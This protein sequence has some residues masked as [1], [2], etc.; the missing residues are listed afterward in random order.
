VDGLKVQFSLAAPTTEP[1]RTLQVETDAGSL[2][3]VVAGTND[4]QNIPTPPGKT[5]RLRLS[6]GVTDGK[7]P[8]GVSIAEITLPGLQPVSRLLVP[9]EDRQPSALVFRNQQIGRSA[10]LHAGTRPLCRQGFAKD[11]EE[12]TGLMRSVELPQAASYQLQGTALPRDGAALEGML[13]VPGAITASASSR[14]VT[15]PE[16]RPG[17]A[18]DRDQGT[19]WVASSSDLHPALTLKLPEARKL[20]GLQFLA[21]P[22]LAASQPAEVALSFDGGTPVR[23]TVDAEGYVRFGARKARTIELT[24]T[25]TKPLV[26]FDSATGYAQTAPVGVAEVRVLGADDLRKALDPDSETGAYCGYGPGVRV[27]GVPADTQLKATVGDLLQRRPVTYTTC[28][29][30]PLQAGRHTLDVLATGAFV[31]VEATFTKAGYGNVSQT[32]VQGIDVWRPNPAELSVEVPA[33]DERSVLT[34]AQNYNEGWEAYDGSGRKL[35]PIRVDGWQ[36]GWILPV[37]PEQ[38]V[39]ARFMPDRMYR[40][41]LLVGLLGLL[42]VIAAAVFFRRRSRHSRH[43][44]R[45]GRSVGPWVALGLGLAA[46]TFM[47]GWIGFAAVAIAAACTWFLSTRVLLAVLAGAVT[48]GTLIAVVQP[49]PDGGA[50]LTSGVVQASIL[51]GC[52]LALLSRPAGETS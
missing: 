4:P 29:H 33:A 2:A 42:V 10:C 38:V 34:V 21:D 1:V 25:G 51:F 5:Q 28:E 3:S 50:G 19:G 37:G 18:V 46:G 13:T 32:P 44:L 39:T 17:A 52:A 31:P 14:A 11:S 43:R 15:A 49:W 48:V 30:V 36:Q 40:A 20:S 22:Y 16:G 7:N 41:G 8:N 23:R 26:D 27:D 9:S 35:T 6:V 47:S 24:F 12:P 45:E